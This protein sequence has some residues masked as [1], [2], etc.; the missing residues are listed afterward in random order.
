MK[1]IKYIN[2]NPEMGIEYDYKAIIKKI[3]SLGL[4]PRKKKDSDDVDVWNPS[5]VPFNHAK[6]FVF[7]SLRS[8]GK[9]TNFLILGLIM[10]EMYGTVTQYITQTENQLAP[11]NSKGLYNV[12]LS[13]DYIRKIT[14]GKWSSICLKARRWY[15]CNHDDS[16]KISEMSKDYVCIMSSIDKQEQ[17]KSVLNEPKG[18]LI[19]FDEFI[20]KYYMPN[21]FIEFS[22]LFSTIRR[23]RQSPII[24]MLSNTVNP[25]S[26][27]FSELE[28]SDDVLAMKAGDKKIITSDHGTNVYVE[29]IDPAQSRSRIESDKLFFGFHNPLLGAITGNTLW[30][31]KNYP[32]IIHKEG[33]IQL[34]VNHYILYNNKLV[35]LELWKSDVGLEIHAHFATKTYDD[36]VIYTLGEIRRPLDR[37]KYGHTKLDKTIWNCFNLNRFYY[38]TNDVGTF[39]ENYINAC[40]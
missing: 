33:D 28:I 16:G 31:I 10:H 13:N 2:D 24:I 27:Y 26:T 15:Y 39:V 14:N 4:Y 36:S 11:K 20:H 6:W 35:N 23:I 12:I 22:Q 21:E 32:H 19:I 1:K 18:D 9:T 17:Y 30:S 25:Y 5:H 38:S 3:K 37:F 8:K 29:I 40:K 34:S 7:M